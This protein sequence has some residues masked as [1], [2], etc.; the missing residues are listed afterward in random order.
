[1][2]VEVSSIEAW[3]AALIS[4]TTLGEKLAPPP[5]PEAF[6]SVRPTPL[7]VAAPGRPPEL[8]VA[9]RAPKA[10]RPGALRDPARAAELLHSFFHHELQAAELMAWAILA[11]P[12]TPE[13]FRRGLL[14][15]A[16]DEIRHARML[17]AEI[18]RLGQA[19]GAFPVRDWFWQRVPS[20]KTPAAFVA[21]MGVGLEGGNLDHSARWAKLLR[22]A[23]QD[24]TAA[25][26][27]R[28][29]EEE[30]PHVRF[31]TRW[32]AEL[33]GDAGW[34]RWIA[35]LPP[36]LTPLLF[37]GKPIDRARRLRAGM[38]ADFVDALERWSP[39]PSEREAASLPARPDQGAGD[40][41]PARK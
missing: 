25:V 5:P 33:A 20:V 4:G 24:T 37:R 18:E 26:V 32:L 21:L 6:A 35:T 30:I 15:I 40:E 29:G 16:E 3:C 34:D 9:L 13:T 14:R 36:P 39:D 41:T 31:A 19:I 10:P 28:I 11:F 23:R 7:R 27:A 8:R 1:M 12:E 38:S 22:D 17:G 2:S